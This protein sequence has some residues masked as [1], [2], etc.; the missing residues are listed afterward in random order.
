MP[1]PTLF[2]RVAFRSRL[3]SQSMPVVPK[4]TGVLVTIIPPMKGRAAYGG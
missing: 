2:W 4:V 1:F 3:L